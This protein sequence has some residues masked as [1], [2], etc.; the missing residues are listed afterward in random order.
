MLAVSPMTTKTLSHYEILAP[1]GEGG[2][3]VVYRAVDVR[4]GRPVA[5]KLLRHDGAISEESRKRFVHEARAASALNHPHIVT[6][7][8]IGQ[9]KGVDFIAMDTSRARRWPSCLP[10]TDCR[11]RTA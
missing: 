7:Y 4:L 3:G 11:L 2:M 1:I 5:I 8:D 9:D 10:A 6:I